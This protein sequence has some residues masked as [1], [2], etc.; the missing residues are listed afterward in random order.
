M[1]K[2]LCCVCLMSLLSVDANA[3]TMTDKWGNTNTAD[4]SGSVEFIGVSNYIGF[5]FKKVDDYYLLTI[6]NMKNVGAMAWFNYGDYVFTDFDETITG[7]SIV[8]NKNYF[9]TV[10]NDYEFTT[11]SITMDFYRGGFFHG[12][13]GEE[14]VFRIDTTSSAPVPEPKTMLLF[15]AGLVSLSGLARKRSK[16]GAF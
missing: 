3:L 2:L 11:D 10:V 12:C 13:S 15:G 16:V 1:K 9:G 7:M 14:L 6:T 8:S 4:V 5:N